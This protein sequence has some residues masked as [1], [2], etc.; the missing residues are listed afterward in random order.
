LIFLV[1][2]TGWLG[3]RIAHSGSLFSLRLQQVDWRKKEEK[4]ESDAPSFIPT[5]SQ[6]KAA[7]GRSVEARPRCLKETK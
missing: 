2:S 4:K 6:L 5:S 7:Q 1:S 3:G